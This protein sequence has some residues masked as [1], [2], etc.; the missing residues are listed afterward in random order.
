MFFGVLHICKVQHA[1]DPSLAIKRPAT[2]VYVYDE[3]KTCMD[4][5]LQRARGYVCVNVPAYLQVLTVILCSSGLI[6]GE[7][8]PDI[9]A[10]TFLDRVSDEQL[11][12]IGY[13]FLDHRECE[14]SSFFCSWFC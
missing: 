2:T 13:S 4:E 1:R 14:R 3:V 7:D 8:A 10:N 6:E 11:Q 9:V 12:E 5:A